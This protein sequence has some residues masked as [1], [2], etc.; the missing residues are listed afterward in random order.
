M[1][2]VEPARTGED[3]G[4]WALRSSG[5]YGVLVLGFRVSNS[6]LRSPAEVL[7]SC[8]MWVRR[9]LAGFLFRI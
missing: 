6:V 3:S 1:A 7:V 2:M 4:F 9:A 8:D 5:L